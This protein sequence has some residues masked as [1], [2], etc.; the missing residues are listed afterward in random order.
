MEKK[1]PHYSLKLVKRLIADKERDPF[2]QSA[3]NGAA[4]M[5]LNADELRG[6]VAGLTV[7]DFYK[8]MTTHNSSIVWQD[9]YRPVTRLGAAYVKVT[10][11][12]QE[13]LIVVSF[14]EL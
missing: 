10:I 11:Y 14:K 7:R 13:N 5:G 9:V 6:V 4:E 2:T 3:K 8:S 1:R 12:P